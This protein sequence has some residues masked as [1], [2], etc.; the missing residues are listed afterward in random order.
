MRIEL[1]LPWPPSVNHYYKRTKAGKVFISDKGKKYRLSVLEV[2]ASIGN[3]S[4]GSANV[5][6]EVEAFPPDNR[7]RDLDNIA[8]KALFD[9][10]QHACIYDDDRQIKKVTATMHQQTL[11]GK[12]IVRISCQ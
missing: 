11:S 4:F 1:V 12:T 5:T 10:L 3:P 6:V 8:G 2:I 7:K 9:A